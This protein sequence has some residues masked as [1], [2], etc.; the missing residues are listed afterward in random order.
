MLDV[1]IKT[2]APETVAYLSMRGP[3]AQIPEAMGRLYR[4]VSQQGL[5]P[6]GMP[7]GVYFDDPQTV[8]EDSSRW[9]VQT[10]VAGDPPTLDDSDGMGI[11]RVEPRLVA[12]VMY[13][14]AYEHI[15]PT[16]DQLGEWIA[17]NGYRIVGPPEELYYSDP[18]TTAPKDYV[19]EIRFPVAPQ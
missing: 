3:Y 10:P 4:W 5:Q 7:A 15:A 2:T 17:S 12:S 8:K 16:Y 9:A 14:G 19:T 13:H 18:A 1:E 6:A 11:K